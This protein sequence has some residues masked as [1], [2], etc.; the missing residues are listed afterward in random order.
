MNN[1]TFDE[2]LQAIHDDIQARDKDITIE[3]PQA[4]LNFSSK[5]HFDKIRPG[6]DVIVRPGWTGRA[7]FPVDGVPG[8]W[9]VA[10][11]GE[12]NQSVRMCDIDV[13]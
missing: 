8:W 13:V 3:L 7:L 11:P 6:D 2:Y 12:L 1:Q 5:C 10:K 4:T 9:V